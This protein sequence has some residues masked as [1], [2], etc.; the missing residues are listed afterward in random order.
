M[1]LMD[2]GY[3]DYDFEKTEKPAP[4]VDWNDTVKTDDEV[5]GILSAFGPWA[6]KYK[7]KTTE[8]IQEHIIKTME[9]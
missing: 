2:K 1:I 8:D 9:D 7:P 3:Y 6:N 5:H 4:T